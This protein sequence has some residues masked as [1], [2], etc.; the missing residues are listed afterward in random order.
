MPLLISGL[1]PA[2]CFSRFLGW[3]APGS[4]QH[5]SSVLLF[6]LVDR[7]CLVFVQGRVHAPNKA[8]EDRM[9]RQRRAA[10]LFS[11]LYQPPLISPHTHPID[12]MPSHHTPPSHPNRSGRPAIVDTNATGNAMKAASGAPVARVVA[13]EKEDLERAG[14]SGNVGGG[15]ALMSSPTES[16]SFMPSSAGALDSNN[17]SISSSGTGVRGCWRRWT[18]NETW[19]FHDLPVETV[20][21]S[22]FSDDSNNKSFLMYVSGVVW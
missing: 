14:G 9:G 22:R 7:V 5:L 21:Y 6:L 12:A 13:Q 1:S 19:F 20:S 16:G 15:G 18:S 17:S 11:Q 3:V 2:A 8:T 4:H 10:H